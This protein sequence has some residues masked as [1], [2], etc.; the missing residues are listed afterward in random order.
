M[1][2]TELLSPADSSEDTVMI[3]RTRNLS[4]AAGSLIACTLTACFTG[5]ALVPDPT[6]S[7]TTLSDEPG[8]DATTT[9]STETPSTTAGGETSTNTSQV[10]YTSDTATT[11]SEP[12]AEPFGVDGEW[13]CESDENC[14]SNEWKH[15]NIC[16]FGYCETEACALGSV[17]DDKVGRCEVQAPNVYLSDC[18]FSGDL[19]RHCDGFDAQAIDQNVNSDEWICGEGGIAW[20]YLGGESPWA[21]AQLDEHLEIGWYKMTI[22]GLKVIAEGWDKQGFISNHTLCSIMQQSNGNVPVVSYDAIWTGM[23]VSDSDLASAPN[24]CNN[25]STTSG[26]GSVGRLQSTNA[27]YCIG[28]IE[29]SC[30]E[31]H[32]ILCVRNKL[33]LNTGS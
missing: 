14:E 3:R 11:E 33:G 4:F 19:T 16:T 7:S 28:K 25:W 12:P 21:R 32:Y 6:D 2:Y 17:N 27:E 13:E 22:S 24:N 9:A 31:L 20:L 8:K 15:N 23:I 5:P 26:E 1:R 18:K 29:L 10:G 30:S